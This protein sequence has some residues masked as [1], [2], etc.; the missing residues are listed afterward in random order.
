MRNPRHARRSAA[1]SPEA[2]HRTAWPQARI[3]LQLLQKAAK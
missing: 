2:V 1:I 3:R